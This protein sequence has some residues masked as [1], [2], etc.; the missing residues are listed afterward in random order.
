MQSKVESVNQEILEIAMVAIDVIVA[1]T[2]AL[3][4]FLIYFVPMHGASQ[5]IARYLLLGMFCGVI[6]VQ[7][8]RMNGR[9]QLKRVANQRDRQAFLVA[10]WTFAALSTGTVIFLLKVGDEFSRGWLIAFWLLGLAALMLARAVATSIIR[11]LQSK[12]ALRRRAVVVGTGERVEQLL[13]ELSGDELSA[14]YLVLDVI[15]DGQEGDGG[16]L[17]AMRQRIADLTRYVLVNNIDQVILAIEPEHLQRN[18]GLVRHI[19]DL[20]VDVLHVSEPIMVPLANRSFDLIGGFPV[21]TVAKVPTRDW[22]YLI[23]RAIDMMLAWSLLLLL[24]PLLLAVSI[25]VKLTS[26]GPVIFRQKRFGYGGQPIEVLKF[27]SMYV[28]SQDVAGAQRTVRGDRRITPIGAFIRRMSIDELPQLINILRGDMSI[29]GPRPHPMA[30]KV[31]EEY[32][33]LAIQGYAGRHKVLPG[34]TGWAQVNGSR[35]EI[36]TIKQAHRRVKL[37]LFYIENW[38][39]AFDLRILI[40]TFVCIFDTKN[41]Y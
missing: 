20:P 25:G 40:R 7:I 36:K 23:K 15:T 24:L 3:A 37:D 39:L 9:Y 41:A 32:Y 21:L 33:H 19:H 28:D 26:E 30:M 35:G 10:S 22:R 1:V 18:G 31:G 16:G 17:A 13:W 6:F 27:R 5:P 38:S 34:L 11:S 12:G 29:V 2:A 14:Q 4:A 8:G